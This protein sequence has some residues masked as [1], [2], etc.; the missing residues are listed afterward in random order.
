M[1]LC[2]T[3]FEV[4]HMPCIKIQK[5]V[6]ND[7][8]SIHSGSASILVSSYDK[9]IKGHSRKTVREKLGRILYINEGHTCGIFLSPTRGL[10]DYDAEKD[11]F[12]IVGSG[13]PRLPGLGVFPAPPVHTVFG[14][15]YLVLGFAEKCGM[16]S[17]LRDAFTNTVDYEK[18]ICH[19]LHTIC[20]DGSKISCDDFFTRSVASC[21]LRDIPVGS[22]GA[23][24]PYFMAMGEDGAKLAF[25]RSFIKHMRRR[26]PDFGTGCYV[27]STPLPNDI[28]D[29]PLNALCFHGVASASVQTRL[30]LV[31]DEETG[32]PVWFQTIPGNVLDLSTISGVMEDVAESLG[33]RIGSLVLD[34]GYVTKSVIGEFNADPCQPAGAEGDRKPRTIVARMPAKKGYPHRKLYNETRHLYPNAKYEFI[35]KSHTYFGTVREITLFGFRM[36]AYVYVDKDN[37]LT[38]G[39]KDREKDEDAYQRLTMA[40]KNWHSVKYGYFVLLS[41]TRAEP[42][43]MLDEYFGRTSIETVFKTGKDFL[44]LLPLSKWSMQTVLGKL[45]SDTICT[46]VYLELLKALKGKEISMPKL[47]GTTSSLMCLRKADGTICVETPNKGTKEVYSKVGIKIPSSISRDDI[48]KKLGLK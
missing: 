7:D 36:Y 32:L 34:A 33:I 16:V 20:K 47:L 27:D 11:E 17:V 29:N 26:Y 45:L 24:T 25:F 14:D 48:C 4:I 3:I 8:G 41:N 28:A 43:Q 21:I 40:E 35:R 31:L 37:A 19:L 15:A 13:D 30:V 9:S 12:A 5:L 46:I 44:S 18:V 6:F 42:P 2:S 22:L 1:V 10:V 38:L 23:D 39:R